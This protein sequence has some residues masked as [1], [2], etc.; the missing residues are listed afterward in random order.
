ML[1][2]LYRER[3]NVTSTISC[4]KN[5]TTKYELLKSYLNLSRLKK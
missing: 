1:E 3:D 5:K 2:T 4:K